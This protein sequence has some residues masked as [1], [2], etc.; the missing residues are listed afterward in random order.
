MCNLDT[1]NGKKLPELA[2]IQSECS[3]HQD[4]SHHAR[5]T[6]F[7]AVSQ[8]KKRKQRCSWKEHLYD[9]YTSVTFTLITS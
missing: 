1:F 6:G 7:L 9:L 5:L 4:A 3:A 8:T 2:E